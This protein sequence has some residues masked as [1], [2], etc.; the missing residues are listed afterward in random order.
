MQKGAVKSRYISKS[1]ILS[2][3]SIFN[4][5]KMYGFSGLSNSTSS[6]SINNQ[7]KKKKT[8]IKNIKKKSTGTQKHNNI[9]FLYNVNNLRSKGPTFI[10]GELI[11]DSPIMEKSILKK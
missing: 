5:Y 2:K 3:G 9:N 1:P 11:Q 6:S 8:P 10:S 4:R 7:K